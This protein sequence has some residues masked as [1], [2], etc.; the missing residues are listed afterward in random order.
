MFSLARIVSCSKTKLG[1]VLEPAR[2]LH[3]TPARLTADDAEEFQRYQRQNI[4]GLENLGVAKSNWSWPKYNRIV[5]PP[6]EEGEPKR[7]AFVHHM[8]TFI[9]YS[10]K[11]LW[12]PAVM[13]KL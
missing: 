1:T 2:L 5:Y 4:K 9:K 10:P 12:F 13:V 6:Q 3:V 8:R 11:K 7:N